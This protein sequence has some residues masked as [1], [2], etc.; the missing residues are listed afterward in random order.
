MKK[1]QA[2]LEFLSVYG[3]ALM[4]MLGAI[5][6]LGMT[7]LTADD[8]L[9]ESCNFLGSELEC[10]DYNLN[11]GVVTFA[12]KNIQRLPIT[13]NSATCFYE[14][15]AYV[16]NE[17]RQ[18]IQKDE[19]VTIGCEFQ[20]F[21]EDLI[22]VELVLNYNEFDANFPTTKTVNLVSREKEESETFCMGI[23]PTGQGTLKG[24]GKHT[25]PLTWNYTSSFTADNPCTWSCNAT[26]SKSGNMCS[27]T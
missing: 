15:E 6:L 13:L 3:F 12:I 25:E 19:I 17:G 9:Q 16:L 20:S 11:N 1:S 8:T 7:F 4:F 24:A 14:D 18:T 21:S 5:F 2:S 22:N 27:Q 23:S 10:V 26:T